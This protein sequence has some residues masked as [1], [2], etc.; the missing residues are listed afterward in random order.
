MK[1]KASVYLVCASVASSTVFRGI[2]GVGLVGTRRPR[3]IKGDACG[4]SVGHSKL[5]VMFL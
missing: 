2:R 5:F 3:T 4:P 1:S